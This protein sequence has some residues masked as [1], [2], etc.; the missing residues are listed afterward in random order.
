MFYID[1]IL[2]ISPVADGLQIAPNLPADWEWASVKSYWF[3]G[4]EYSIRVDRAAEKP[5]IREG[6][7]TVPA[8]GIYVLNQSGNLA[9]DK[10]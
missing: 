8:D 3:N 6:E 2:G 7:I 4:K 5:R 1:G 10:K 9:R